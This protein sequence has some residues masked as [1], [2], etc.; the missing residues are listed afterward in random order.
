MLRLRKHSQIRWKYIN[1]FA[2]I[3]Q[4]LINFKVKQKSKVK[5][6]EWQYLVL[7]GL[8]DMGMF[9]LI[10]IKSKQDA[11]Q[12]PLSSLKPS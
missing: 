5:V 11:H 8:T 2:K 6:I 12:L 4:V 9:T 3:K 10:L 1:V 7:T